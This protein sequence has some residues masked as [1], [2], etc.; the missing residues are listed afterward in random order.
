MGPRSQIGV[1]IGN[2][3]CDRRCRSCLHGV[4]LFKV[5]VYRP[6]RPQGQRCRS[7]SCLPPSQPRRPTRWPRCRRLPPSQPRRSSAKEMVATSVAVAAGAE[8]VAVDPRRRSGADVASV[9]PCLRARGRR[10]LGRSFQPRWWSKSLRCLI[11]S[12]LVP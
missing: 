7:Q 9:D 5:V 2:L 1:R 12:L 8:T 4:L 3:S 10:C 11:V 6:T